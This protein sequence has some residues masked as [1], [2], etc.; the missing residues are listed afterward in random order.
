[1]RRPRRAELRSDPMIPATVTLASVLL[2]V[3]LALSILVTVLSLTHSDA[4]VRL[5][6]ARQHGGLSAHA[7]RQ[8]VRDGLYER[9]V[10]NL[11]IGVWYFFL[12]TRLRRRRWWAWRR[13]VWISAVGSLG[14][15]Y[16]LTQPYTAV[17]KVEQVVQ[18]VVLVSIGACTL[19]PATRTFVGPRPPKESRRRRLAGN[20]GGRG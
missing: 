13:M 16:L 18:L 4:L 15:V 6:L 3:N 17:F 20:L 8:V 9:A 12:V 11:A 7:T 5:A 10:V 14:I 2:V 1:M 19:H